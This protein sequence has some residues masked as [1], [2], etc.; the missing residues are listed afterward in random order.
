ML[1]RAK[2]FRTQSRPPTSK[3]RMGPWHP[4]GV[5]SVPSLTASH[6]QKLD[7]LIRT[8]PIIRSAK[9]SS[10]YPAHFTLGSGRRTMA[11]QT[12]SHTAQQQ[13]FPNCSTS[14]LHVAAMLGACWGRRVPMNNTSSYV[15]AGGSTSTTTPSSHKRVWHPPTRIWWYLAVCFPDPSLAVPLANAS[16]AASELSSAKS[17]SVVDLAISPDFH[18]SPL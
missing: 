7:G 12:A 11:H 2:T 16:E 18:Q 1:L 15:P 17:P 8:E 5:P 14:G 4:N 9:K 10:F 6:F 13:S 3:P